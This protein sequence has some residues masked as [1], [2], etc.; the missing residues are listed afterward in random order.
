MSRS[1][2]KNHIP[3]MEIEDGEPPL[4][5]YRKKITPATEAALWSLSNGRCYAPGCPFPV[6]FET[7][8]GVYKKNA[9]VAHIHGVRAPRYNPGLTAEQCAAFSNLVLLCLPHHSEVDDRKTGE[10]Y[11]PAGLLRKWKTEHEG[12][13][14][15]ALA[16]LGPVDEDTLTEMLLDVFSPPLERL[17]Q[18]ADRLEETGTL[19]AQTVT[20]LRQVIDVMST[21]ASGLDAQTAAMLVDAAEVYGS[22]EF[23]QAAS[24]L[25]DASEVLPNLSDLNEKISQLHEIAELIS[26]STQRMGGYM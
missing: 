15:P 12:S 14:G 25:T 4:T 19:N 9:Q 8:P 23:R 10:Q 20:E 1:G 2:V 21:T 26:S 5:G 7:R 17:E 3:E 11:Y 13:N 16:A 6:V 22:H 24:M 18:I